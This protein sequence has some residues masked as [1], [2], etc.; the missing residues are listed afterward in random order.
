MISKIKLIYYIL[1]IKYYNLYQK[2]KTR[3]IAY[4]W[5]NTPYITKDNP[6]RIKI[7]KFTTLYNELY[8]L[9]Y[10]NQ[11]KTECLEACGLSPFEAHTSNL[12]D[13]YTI[14]ESKPLM[15]KIFSK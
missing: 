1:I 2:N 15:I 7:I 12:T 3:T 13:N 5:Y 10:P 14:D 6:K 11:V 4:G 9:M 8:S